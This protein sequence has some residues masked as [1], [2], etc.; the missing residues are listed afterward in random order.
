MTDEYLAA[1]KAR[2]EAAP[3]GPWTVVYCTTS[4]RPGSPACAESCGSGRV[5]DDIDPDGSHRFILRDNVED[6][7]SGDDH[8][9]CTGH[10]YDDFGYISPEVAEFIGCARTDIPALLAE[11]DRLKAALT[12]LGSCEAFVMACG[13]G[14]DMRSREIV[15][16]IDYARAALR[17]Q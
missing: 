6:V 13:L 7:T 4:H 10:D 11:I 5:P 16:R 3:E 17:R 14:P 12:R 15:A 9:I 2:V 8:I 1:I